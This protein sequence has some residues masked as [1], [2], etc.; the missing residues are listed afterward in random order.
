M[1]IRQTTKGDLSFILQLYKTVAENPRG[2]ARSES[3]INEDYVQ[4]LWQSI[5]NGGLG[6]VAIADERIVGEIHAS[7]KGIAIFAHVLS[8][9]T[10]G[11]HPNFQGQGM[12]RFLFNEFLTF[13]ENKRSDIYRVELESRAS[14]SAG[15]HLYESV[16]F[17]LEGRMKNQTRNADGTHEDGVTYAWFNKNYQCMI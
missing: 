2:I 16:G 10:I 8:A 13:V 9:L 4:N 6:F 7:Q 17:Q 1:H 11:V 12:G 5:Q 3:E 15:I 14:N